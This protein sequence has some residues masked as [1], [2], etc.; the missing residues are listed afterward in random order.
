MSFVHF[1]SNEFSVSVSPCNRSRCRPQRK[2]KR[3]ADL[4]DDE[5][6]EAA[7]DDSDAEAP[8]DEDDDLIVDLDLH[9]KAPSED[10]EGASRCRVALSTRT[11]SFS[12]VRDTQ[13]FF[14]LPLSMKAPIRLTTEP[15]D[16]TI[17]ACGGWPWADEAGSPIIS[18]VCSCMAGHG[19]G[20]NLC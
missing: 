12:A 19:S 3:L 6:E 10:E 2:A 1:G 11:T 15:H 9:L 20:L 5:D 17:A 16:R 14:S 18:T 7:I 8:A 4:V 13:C